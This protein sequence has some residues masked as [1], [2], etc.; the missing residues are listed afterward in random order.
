M[1][2]VET[3]PSS[4]SGGGPRAPHHTRTP[5]LLFLSPPMHC[6]GTEEYWHSYDDTGDLSTFPVLKGSYIFCF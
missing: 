3:E 2:L 5:H 1:V 4:S 6:P